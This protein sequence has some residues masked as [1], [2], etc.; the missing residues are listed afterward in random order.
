MTST[1][2]AEH[3]ERNGNHNSHQQDCDNTSSTSMSSSSSGGGG[4]RGCDNVSIKPKAVPVSAQHTYLHESNSYLD[5]MAATKQNGFSGGAPGDCS[6]TRSQLLGGGGRR[7]DFVNAYQGSSSSPSNN[8]TSSS[9][10]S[11]NNP[12]TTAVNQMTSCNA[13]PGGASTFA[14]PAMSR[15]IALNGGNELRIDEKN[16]SLHLNNP[17]ATLPSYEPMLNSGSA[18]SGS[19]RS[20]SGG[21]GDDRSGVS[22]QASVESQSNEN[23]DVTGRNSNTNNNNVEDLYAQII[24]PKRP[25]SIAVTSLSTSRSIDLMST[26]ASSTNPSSSRLLTT[27]SSSSSIFNAN[28]PGGAREQLYP[29]GGSPSSLNLTGSCRPS[30]SCSTL[31]RLNSGSASKL[32]NDMS[33]LHTPTTSTL[34]LQHQLLLQQQQHLQQQQQQ[35]LSKQA[36]F[37]PQRRS[38][39]TPRPI[40]S[41]LQPATTSYEDH[42]QM[43]SIATVSKT[44]ARPK[45]LDRGTAPLT[46]YKTLQ[47]PVTRR[48]QQQQYS[49]QDHYHNTNI[50]TGLRQSATFHGQQMLQSQVQFGSGGT[51]TGAT[52]P[53]TQSG[54]DNNGAVGGTRRKSERPLSYAYGTM[55]D[56]VFLENQLR[57]YSEQLKT[58]TESVRKY[59]EQ[60]KLLSEMKRQQMLAKQQQQQQHMNYSIPVSASETKANPLRNASDIKTGPPLPTSTPQDVQTPSHQLRMFLDD[61]RSNIKDPRPGNLLIEESKS[62]STLPRNYQDA[63]TPMPSDHLRQFLDHIRSSQLAREQQDAIASG[64]TGGAMKPP[65][66]P[67]RGFAKQNIPQSVSVNSLDSLVTSTTPENKLRS[68]SSDFKELQL[69]ATTTK[70]FSQISNNL[71]IMNQDLESFTGDDRKVTAVVKQ[72][73]ARP[74]QLLMTATTSQIVPNN[75]FNNSNNNNNSKS[76]AKLVTPSLQLNPLLK[77]NNFGSINNISDANSNNNGPVLLDFNQILDNFQLMTD[78]FSATNPMDYLKKYSEALRETSDQIRKAA[79]VATRMNNKNNNNNCNSQ[80]SNHTSLTGNSGGLNCGSTGGNCGSSDDNSSCSTTPGSIR[81]A[82]QNLLQ[83]PRNGVQVMDDRMRLFIDILDTQEKFS[84]VL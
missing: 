21:S 2:Q 46:G 17:F 23:A 32:K 42:N 74:T 25:H 60:A 31:T 63:K 41:T 33:G 53:T 10:C 81:E 82:V 70:S 75:N 57:I 76:S 68:K 18:D 9:V 65:P 77:D 39:S 58:I 29:S 73:A 20:R 52:T 59:S 71:Q 66:V 26:T 56:Q 48:F 13:F 84:Q 44:N 34:S 64:P 61:I 3:F 4:G 43:Q 36:P 28:R 80:N 19:D 40:Q 50:L 7:Q 11:N 5:L 14:G 15:R 69:S 72:A 30:P 49:N 51:V 16:I 83:M 79:A 35:L 8:S 47:N 54:F 27:S 45:S 1:A 67:E 22:R 12:T 38:H 78:N 6:A 24:R 37:V 55:P 62:F